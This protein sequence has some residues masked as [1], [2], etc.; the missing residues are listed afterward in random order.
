M[1]RQTAF[2]LCRGPMHPLATH[3]R[4]APRVHMS[5]AEFKGL[6]AAR[7]AGLVLV[8]FISALVRYVS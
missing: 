6:V 5:P 8:L 4:G 7:S 3:A 1:R 2:Q